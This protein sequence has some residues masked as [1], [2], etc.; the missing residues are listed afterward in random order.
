MKF[1][2]SRRDRRDRRPVGEMHVLGLERISFPLDIMNV[3][4]AVKASHLT[5][6]FDCRHGSQMP[7]SE[8]TLSDRE[9][10]LVFVFPQTASRSV[11]VESLSMR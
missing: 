7:K 2:L 1:C 11:L 10:V 5:S 4:L 6:H 3:D 8:S 9:G